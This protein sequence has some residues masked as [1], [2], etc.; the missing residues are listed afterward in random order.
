M[1][2]KNILPLVM[3]CVSLF[4][5]RDSWAQTTN[6]KTYSIFLY[7]FAKYIEWPEGAKSGDFVIAVYGSPKML[8][9]LQGSAV[10]RKVGR[11]DIK[12]IEVRTL[13]DLDGAHVVFVG[14]GKSGSTDEI[15]NQFKNSPLLVVTERDGLVKK[16]ACVSF[17]VDDDSSLKFQLNEIAI[18]DKKLRTASALLNLAYKGF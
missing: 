7:S 4:S 11:Q 17:I 14:D 6:Y 15:V 16:G 1:N 5:F 9:E 10:G 2:P 18:N 12:I 3:L 13:S 8:A